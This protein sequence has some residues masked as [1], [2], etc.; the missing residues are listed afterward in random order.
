MTLINSYAKSAILQV[1]M[2]GIVSC[3]STS[4]TAFGIGIGTFIIILA[5][6]FSVVWCLACRSSQR[7]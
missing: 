5:I 6:I 4:G 3:Q 1:M 7:P 2:A